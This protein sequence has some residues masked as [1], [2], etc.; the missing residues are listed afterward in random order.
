MKMWH[1]VVLAAM[2]MGSAVWLLRPTEEA[3]IRKHFQVLSE[4]A[5][6]EGSEGLLALAGKAAETADLFAD[7]FLFR[8]TVGLPQGSLDRTE[9]IRMVSMI[10]NNCT[11]AQLDF[12]D[13]KITVNGSAADAVVTAEFNGSAMGERIHEL[14]EFSVQLVKRDGE[15]L[16]RSF[17]EVP[18]LE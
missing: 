1:I 4:K 10:R 12:Y 6:K 7:P 3:R 14:R 9:L 2:V 5:E 15:W 18:V 8:S 11:R 16:F 13:L 17:E